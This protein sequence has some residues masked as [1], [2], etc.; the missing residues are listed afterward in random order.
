MSTIFLPHLRCEVSILGFVA[1]IGLSKPL[2]LG[3]NQG[4]S[5][6]C[7]LQRPEE[8]E[9]EDHVNKWNLLLLKGSLYY[10]SALVVTHFYAG[11]LGYGNMF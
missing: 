2:I 4:E 1:N 9:R 6:V 10:T 11:N 7:N 5:A 3:A 8:E